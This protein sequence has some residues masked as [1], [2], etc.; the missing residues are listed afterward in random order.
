MPTFPFPKKDLPAPTLHRVLKPADD[1]YDH[2]VHARDLPFDA[3]PSGPDGRMTFSHLNTW[4]LADASL[5]SYWP[6]DVAR[7]RFLDDAGLENAFLSER[8]TQCYVAWNDTFAI[9]AFRGTQPDALLD[10]IAD[11]RLLLLPWRVD[12]ERVHDGFQSALQDVWPK[13]IVQ[14]KALKDRRVWFTG[15]SLGAALAT[16]A[17]DRFLLERQDHGFQ[18]P[19]GVYTFGSPLVGDRAFA[20]GFNGRHRDR[21]FRF[22]NDQDGVTTVPFPR[23]GYRHVN[24]ERFVGFDDPDVNRFAENV[25][26]HTP[27]RYATL[28]W[29]ALVDA[30][31]KT[32]P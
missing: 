4:W 32:G 15:H 14:L 12:G 21:S 13:L 2:F 29:N 8:S 24:D 17:I 3:S 19:G 26:D 6:P 27:R 28:A 7:Q 9:V 5:L 1:D 10:L 23:L 30:G 20:G 31:S 22:V 16:L 18:E 25:I 11:A